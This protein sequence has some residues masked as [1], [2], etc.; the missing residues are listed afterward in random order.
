MKRI[1]SLGIVLALAASGMAFAPKAADAVSADAEDA[2]VIQPMAMYEFDDAENPGKDTSPNGYDLVP[3]NNSTQGEAAMQIK[4]DETTGKNYLS[5]VS[6]RSSDGMGGTSGACLYAPQLGNSGMDFSDLIRDS[7][8][9]TI[10]FR[11]DNTSNI[12]DHYMLTTGRYNDSFQLTPWRSAVQVQV[13]NMYMAPGATDEEKQAWLEA[14]T[15]DIPVVTTDWTTVT[16]STDAETNTAVLYLN[17]QKVE[18]ITMSDTYF[19][20]RADPYAFTLGAQCQI[21][22]F[23]ATMFAT[24]DIEQCRVYDTALSAE[25]VQRLYNGEEAVADSDSTYITSVVSP[26]LSSL[27][28]LATDVNTIDVIMNETLPQ[29]TTATLSD[30]TETDV[31]ILWYMISDTEVRGYISTP[32]AKTSQALL[33][34]EYGYTVRFTYDEDLI[35]VSQV[36]LDGNAY[37]PGTPIDGELHTVTFRVTLL[38]EYSEID[39]VS[40]LGMEW[41]ADDDE[42]NYYLEIAGGADVII[43]AQPLEY[44]VTYY[45]GTEKLG[46]S[47]YTHGGD[48][49]LETFEKEGY[50]FDGWF[51]DEALT[52]TFEGL[53]YENP[54]DIALYAKYT[55]VSD[56]PGTSESTGGGTSAGTSAGGSS[57][58][59]GSVAGISAAALL[60][61]GAAIALKKRR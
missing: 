8:T 42:G 24:V 50:T 19:T 17:G 35:R 23:A 37:T 41:P 3:L 4:K 58:G 26:D 49:A 14:N 51:T 6:D 20:W 59:C 32:Y 48:E 55:A 7:Y 22:G 34:A 38:D 16:V 2:A 52:Q 43:E 30:G 15:T 33:E 56:T 25:N 5:L 57:G 11:R 29:T 10:T 12:G 45:D 54:S 46:E 44:T 18:T 61:A 9:V 39:S 40:Y 31:D 27:D 21:T 47:T 1:L 53:D 28:L 36:R 60:A 13:N